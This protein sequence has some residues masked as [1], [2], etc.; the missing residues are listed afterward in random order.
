MRDDLQ[1]NLCGCGKRHPEGMGILAMINHH[2]EENTVTYRPGNFKLRHLKTLFGE[3]DDMQPFRDLLKFDSFKKMPNYETATQLD[4]AIYSIIRDSD[5]R[6]MKSLRA[7]V[8][9]EEDFNAKY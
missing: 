3:S 5:I 9:K 6:S 2:C 8:E 7:Y 4:K 1:Y